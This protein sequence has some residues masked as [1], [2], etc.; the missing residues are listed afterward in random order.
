LV[1]R[2]GAGVIVTVSTPPAGAVVITVVGTPDGT[3]VS[4]VSGVFRLSRVD[5]AE[6]SAGVPVGVIVVVRPFGSVVVTLA[7]PGP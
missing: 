4:G 3:G 2:G 7:L 5:W 6:P 1:L